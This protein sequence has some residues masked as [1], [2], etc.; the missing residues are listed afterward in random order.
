VLKKGP[1]GKLA[2]DF[3]VRPCRAY[4][5]VND[6]TEQEPVDS[7]SPPEEL[8]QTLGD[9][10]TFFG[11]DVHNAYRQIELHE[12]SKPLTALWTPLGIIQSERV[13]FG[14]KN[15]GTVLYRY[16]MAAFS[17]L[18]QETRS[19][20]LRQADDISS[21]QSNH[22]SMF[23]WLRDFLPVCSSAGI[24]LKATKT[25]CGYPA[26]EFSGHRLEGGLFAFWTTTWLLS[27][28]LWTPMAFPLCVVCWDYST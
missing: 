22:E 8:R 7:G 16:F 5:E 21:G 11:T 19:R 2:E 13:V 17:K 9:S 15:G 20:L 6:E 28:D 24:S 10:I 3:D 4:V 27:A 1:D 25:K 14:L 26:A 12:D 23:L 18:S